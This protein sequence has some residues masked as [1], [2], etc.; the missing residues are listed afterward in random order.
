M[1]PFPAWTT[2]ALWRQGAGSTIPIWL[3]IPQEEGDRCESLV[4]MV[5][6][7]DNILRAVPNMATQVRRLS[8]L[9]R[10]D[11]ERMVQEI[12]DQLEGHFREK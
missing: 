1:P 6:I 3:L 7:V 5:S 4:A 8:E 12:Q 9:P 10:A 11:L 2:P